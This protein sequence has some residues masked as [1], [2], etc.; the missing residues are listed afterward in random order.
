MSDIIGIGRGGIQDG[1]CGI[2]AK[3]LT[4]VRWSSVRV[5]SDRVSLPCDKIDSSDAAN[6]DRTEVKGGGGRESFKVA[7]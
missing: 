1:G 6:V 2:I 4:T 5:S 3:D 7:R